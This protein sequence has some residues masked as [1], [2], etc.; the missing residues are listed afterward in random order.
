MTE[1]PRFEITLEAMADPDNVPAIVRLRRLLKY[2]GRVCGLRCREIQPADAALESPPR[3]PAAT[4]PRPTS[5][6]TRPRPAP[7]GP[8]N[9]TTG[10]KEYAR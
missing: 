4:A 9:A 3:P 8:T 5:P 10:R 2:A 6:P 1:H 7:P